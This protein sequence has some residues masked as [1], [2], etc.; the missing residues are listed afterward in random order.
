MLKVVIE[1]Y[2][3]S[4]ERFFCSC[5]K[6]FK[7]WLYNL[8]WLPSITHDETC[9]KSYKW[10]KLLKLKPWITPPTNILGL[11]TQYFCLHFYYNILVL[12]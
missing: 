6:S 5:F 8:F 10:A 4:M 9:M 12:F 2:F 11:E 1:D 7:L 3:Y